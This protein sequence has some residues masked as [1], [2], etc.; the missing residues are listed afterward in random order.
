LRTVLGPGPAG[1]PSECGR[2]LTTAMPGRSGIFGLIHNE[3]HCHENQ[4]EVHKSMSIGE[5]EDRGLTWNVLGQ[6]ITG[7]D[8]SAP[9]RPTGEGD[10]TAADGHDGYWYAYCLR[11]RDW[12][13]IV[14]RAPRADPAPGKWVK[15]SGSGWDAPGLGGTAAALDGPVGMSS[16]YWTGANAI[17]LLA[18]NASMQLSIST[19]KI[20]FDTVA[21]PIILYDDAN[22]KRPAP[23]DLYAYP[24][25]MSEQGFNTIAG[26]FFLTYTYLPPGQDFS[27]RY[28]VVQ[29]GR[30]HAAPTPRHPQVRTALTRW[31]AADGTTWATTGPAVDPAHS[32][33]YDVNL[34]YLM[35]VAPTGV[36]GVKLDECF[37]APSGNGFLA[38][39]GDCASRGSERHRAAG[40][41]FRFEQPGTI[42]LHSC[43]SQNGERFVSTSPT[44][45][46]AGSHERLLGFALR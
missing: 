45:E 27:Q 44:C 8:G 11:L 40:Y 6:I 30:I 10:C 4:G 17:L 15:W 22:W 20:H 21:E 36:A 2:W 5:S 18:T 23:T 31:I 3:Q 33:R 26:P 13:N 1:S 29:E 39:S 42:G 46:N 37:S 25:M 24:S 16:A 14:A 41:A 43:L 7:D 32:Y 12:K 19:D 35:T 34:G 38:T 9:D 28:L